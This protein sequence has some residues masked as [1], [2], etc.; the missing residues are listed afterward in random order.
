M[1]PIFYINLAARADRREHMEAQF[2][3]I[4]VV[5]ERVEAVTIAEIPEPVLRRIADPQHFWRVREGEV[6][7]A[8]SHQKCWRLMQDRG[9]SAALIFEDDAVFGPALLPFLDDDV[10]ER[11][12]AGLIHLETRR[13]PMALG[14]TIATV[15]DIAL[16]ELGS[17]QK[18][19]AAYVISARAA[20]RSL[21][22]P[23]V[24]DMA[25]DRFLFGRYGPH[26]WRTRILQAVPAPVVQLDALNEVYAR[27]GTVSGVARSDGLK[28]VQ[29]MRRRR[30][31]LRDTLHYELVDF[32]PRLAQIVRTPQVLAPR[33]LVP[34]VGDRVETDRK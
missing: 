30:R 31:R 3:A 4:G 14:R 33:Q 27:S 7:C 17:T 2:R 26:M 11:T 22:S 15:G 12:G 18:G 34:Y 1:L 23:L 21:A 25:P 13:Q 19:A 20:L 32:L 29:P 10:L 16:N 28:A 24:A 9:I 8:L 6:A 5:G